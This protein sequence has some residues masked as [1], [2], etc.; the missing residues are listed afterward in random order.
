MPP[1]PRRQL[2]NLIVLVAFGMAV[3]RIL[4]AELLLEPSLYR[5]PGET[6]PTKRAWPPT[7]PAP[8]PTFSSN[9]RSRWATVRSLVDDGTFVVGRRDVNVVVATGLGPLG[10]TN[11]LEAVALLEAGYRIRI[12]PYPY[13]PAVPNPRWGI[14]AD[15]G[16]VFEDGWGTVDKVLNPSRLEFYST[17][18][19]L[20]EVLVAGEYWLL[21]RATGWT[22]K[23]RPDPVVRII[24][25]TINA[26]PL[27]L[28]LGL[29]ARLLER[30]AG[31]DWGRFF[32][33]VCAAFGTLVTPFLVTFNNHTVGTFSAAVAVYA[34]CRLWEK[35]DRAGWYLLA[36]LAAGFTATNELPAL[37]LTAGLGVVLLWRSWRRTLL[38]YAPAAA[39]PLVAFLAANYAAL[40]ELSP[41]YDKFGGPWYKYE[42]SHWARE[43]E[44]GQKR[45]GIDFAREHET[46]TTYAVHLMVGHHGLF[47][48]TPFVGLSVAGVVMG[49]RRRDGEGKTGP[50]LPAF[51]FPLTAVLSV[52]VVGFYLIKS[53]NYGGWTNGPRWLMWLTPLWLLTMLPA[54]DWLAQR[55]WGRALA[56]T[57][58]VLSILSV[59]YMAWNPWRHPWIYTWMD[60]QGWIPY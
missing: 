31:T 24:L 41:A 17:K 4:S 22:L 39:V 58:L 43:P 37:A 8:M 40:G 15:S 14:Y 6:S 25:L 21:K 30:H 3:G 55:R 56:G 49:L 5:G 50:P 60:S 32:V 12:T 35:D 59:S 11:V 44:P 45:R 57:L 28:Y 33:L 54:V 16:I 29:L 19:P 7:R 23:D 52:V 27:L 48:L 26:L 18:P 1:D 34:V 9:D 10:A 51:L 20:L 46:V 42:G 38:L 2:S 13:P 53:D 36:G 47:S